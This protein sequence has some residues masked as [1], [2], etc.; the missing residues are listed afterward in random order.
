M[1]S[2]NVFTRKSQTLLLLLKHKNHRQAQ[3]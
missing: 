1:D 3:N 2:S